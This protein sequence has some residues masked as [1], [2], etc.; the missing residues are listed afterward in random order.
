VFALHRPPAP[1]PDP[2][3]FMAHLTA[4]TESCGSR[5][6]ELADTQALLLASM[7]P[8]DRK[9]YDDTR[10]GPGFDAA[11]VRARAAV[12]NYPIEEQRNVC[13]ALHDGL[14]KP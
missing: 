2:T 12:A 11:M 6:P 7:E 5:F 3:D 9:L 4:M 13:K 10:R 1:A 14:K 8:D